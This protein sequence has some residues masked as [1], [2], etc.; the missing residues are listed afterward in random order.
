VD[1]IERSGNNVKAIDWSFKDIFTLIIFFGFW[2]M[3]DWIIY[4][5]KPKKIL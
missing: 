4:H 3:I 2:G 1:I 5:L